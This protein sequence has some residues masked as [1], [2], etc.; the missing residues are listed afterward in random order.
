M[1]IVVRGEINVWVPIYYKD[2]MEC[3][4]S[5]EDAH[6]KAGWR[7]L[8][9]DLGASCDSPFWP[10]GEETASHFI[11]SHLGKMTGS[12]AKGSVQTCCF[13]RANGGAQCKDEFHIQNVR[14]L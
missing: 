4:L 10:R 14:G 8:S 3:G 6:P 12:E 1:R 13:Q 5:E 11:V 9:K 2:Q 7:D